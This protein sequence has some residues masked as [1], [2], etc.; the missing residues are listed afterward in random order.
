MNEYDNADMDDLRKDEK[1]TKALVSAAN[2]MTL[3][4]LLTHGAM[5]KF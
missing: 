3:S 2:Y 1:R 4:R 5:S